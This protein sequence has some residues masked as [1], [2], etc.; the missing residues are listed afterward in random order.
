MTPSTD[1]PHSC[2]RSEDELW[3][4]LGSPPDD[5]ER[6]CPTCQEQRRRLAPLAQA[7]QDWKTGTDPEETLL[8][9][10]LGRVMNG[11]RAEIR[12]GTLFTLTVTPHGP[13]RISSY[14]LLEAIRDAVDSIEHVE[15]RTHKI[16]PH[17]AGD[18]TG[19]ISLTVSLAMEAGRG[20]AEV[21]EQTRRTIAA[22]FAERLG[23]PIGT[24]NVTVEDVF[25]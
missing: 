25:Q 16:I 18:G 19:P 17:A 1:A 7:A 15:L 24:I 2:T 22:L 8:E 11:I 3:A 20:S 9:G 12:R 4:S 23:M 5:H 21:A 13:I 6:Q 14:L 10:I